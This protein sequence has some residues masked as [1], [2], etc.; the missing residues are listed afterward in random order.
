MPG[1]AGGEPLVQCVGRWPSTGSPFC[2]ALEEA[3]ENPSENNKINKNNI[4]KKVFVSLHRSRLSLSIGLV[5]TEQTQVTGFGMG[6]GA[7]GRWS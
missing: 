1:G 3:Q 5:P 2:I 4:K 6:L 7:Q